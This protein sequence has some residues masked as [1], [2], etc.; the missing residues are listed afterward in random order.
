MDPDPSSQLRSWSCGRFVVDWRGAGLNFSVRARG[1]DRH[2]NDIYPLT[3]RLLHAYTIAVFDGHSPTA[4]RYPGAADTH[5]HSHP[6]L[7]DHLAAASRV[8]GPA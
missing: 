8:S 4:H 6:C 3:V 1:A 5:T 2:G 7:D